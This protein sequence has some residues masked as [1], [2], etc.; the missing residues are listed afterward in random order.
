MGMSEPSTEKRSLQS[1]SSAAASP[2]RIFPVPARELALQVLA[3]AYGHTSTESFQSSLRSGS[4]SRMSSAERV[5]G[6]TLSAATWRSSAM[7]AYQS[8]LRR[9]TAATRTAEHESSSLLPTISRAAYGSNGYGD[10]WVATRTGRRRPSLQTLAR[11]LELPPLE[12]EP[13]NIGRRLAPRWVEVFMGFPADWTLK[14]RTLVSLRS[15][16]RS[17]HSARKSSATLSAS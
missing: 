12:G 15:V 9:L 16:T 14:L 13:S 7:E 8:R 5:A 11:R 1:T 2:A 17:S 4:W 10:Q 3:A 6:S